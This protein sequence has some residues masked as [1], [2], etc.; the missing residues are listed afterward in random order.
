ELGLLFL[1]EK[2]DI[3]AMRLITTS[4]SECEP[5]LRTVVVL[6]PDWPFIVAVGGVGAAQRDAR[7]RRPRAG[8]ALWLAPR[9]PD[10]W[11]LFGGRAARP[12]TAGVAG[13]AKPTATCRR[14]DRGGACLER[15]CCRRTGGAAGPRHAA[16]AAPALQ[17]EDDGTRARSREAAGGG[18]VTGRRAAAAAAAARP[19]RRRFKGRDGA[20]RS[21]QAGRRSGRKHALTEASPA[22]LCG[23]A[24]PQDPQKRS[25]AYYD[26]RNR[27]SNTVWQLELVDRVWTAY[28]CCCDRT[29]ARRA[30]RGPRR[31]SAPS[32]RTRPDAPATLKTHA[33]PHTRPAAADAPRVEPKARCHLSLLDAIA[34]ETAENLKHS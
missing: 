4:T 33:G 18:A 22:L 3:C 20:G 15:A 24:D 8:A 21:G 19:P 2:W 1:T 13:A 23:R 30:R 26:P 28:M 14:Y 10:C 6:H 17:R 16:A 27:R 11:W 25:L 7:G 34:E 29:D 9:P 32:R 31:R 12:G 5:G